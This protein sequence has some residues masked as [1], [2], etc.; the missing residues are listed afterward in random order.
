MYVRFQ[1]KKKIARITGLGKLSKE[2]IYDE[3][4]ISLNFT[5]DPAYPAVSILNGSRYLGKLIFN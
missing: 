2:I 5:L 3:I 4:F 1:R